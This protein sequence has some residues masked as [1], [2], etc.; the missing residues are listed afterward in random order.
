MT[1]FS[2]L[3]SSVG[4]PAQPQSPAASSPKSAT[5]KPPAPGDRFKLTANNAAAGV[6]RRPE[7]QALGTVAKAAR[8][9]QNGVP[10][11]P[12]AAPSGRFQLSKPGQPSSRP[13]TPGMESENLPKPATK[14]SSKPAISAPGTPTDAAPKKG[15]AAILERAKAQQAAK[16]DAMVGVIKHKAVEKLSR[17]EREKL[18]AEQKAQQKAARKAGAAQNDRS[19]SGTPVGK[20]GASLKKPAEPITY[21]GTMKKAAPEP[22]SY[23]GTMKAP[24]SVPK[25]APK[26]GAAQDKYGG[27]A[28]W[29]DLDEA[30]DEE[31][32][33]DYDS[34]DDM[35]AGFDDMEH[36]ES[37]A[38]KAARKEDLEALE[39]EERHR[40]EKLERKKKLEALSK[41]AAAR[42][43]Y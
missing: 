24:G 4:K 26:K 17:K 30:E 16:K 12:T 1:S 35:E 19:R 15:F 41:S 11:R 8:T 42:K 27:Y 23:R 33:E 40:L 31:E 3:L 39:E 7:E 43:R 20:A 13:N 9:E 21:K 28:S 22:I 2:S 32:E 25:P 36:E 5:S 18:F 6:K 10:S 34:E 38:L 37:A 29:S 14:P